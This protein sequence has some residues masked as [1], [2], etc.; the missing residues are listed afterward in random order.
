MTSEVNKNCDT[1]TLKEDT[2]PSMAALLGHNSADKS[3]SMSMYWYKDSSK[4]KSGP[5]RE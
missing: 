4:I 1:K 3:F 5:I 2:S